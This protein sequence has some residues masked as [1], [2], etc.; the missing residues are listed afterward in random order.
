MEGSV[1][2][3]KLSTW[4]HENSGLFDF[5]SKDLF[6]KKFHVRLS[7][8]VVMEAVRK[9]YDVQLRE[10]TEDFVSARSGRVLLEI[11]R[12]SQGKVIVQVPEQARLWRTASNAQKLK[13][14]DFL[15]F[16]RLKMRVKEVHCQG[17]SASKLSERDDYETEVSAY[18][19]D[20]D[21]LDVSPKSA[22]LCRICYETGEIDNP[23]ISPCACK[24]SMS[25]I[26]VACLRKW[27]TG[28]VIQKDLNGTLSYFVRDIACE[29]CKVSLP[30]RVEFPVGSGVVYELSGVPKPTFPHIVLESKVRGQ[31]TKGLHVV[32]LQQHD[33][34]RE[35]KFGRAVDAD[36]RITDISVSRHHSVISLKNGGFYLQDKSSRFGTLISDGS[37]ALLNPGCTLTVQSGRTLITLSLKK[38]PIFGPV[39]N[40]FCFRKKQTDDEPFNTPVLLSSRQPSIN[41]II[42]RAATDPSPD[43]SRRPSRIFVV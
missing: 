26:H 19:S 38:R 6:S 10:K 33:G 3:V 2:V 15:K 41:R 5:E 21:V 20:L 43:Y 16:G 37:Q 35:L 17:A 24:G 11:A 14:G 27:M 4:N 32:G 23:L 28:K 34:K 22:N 8:Q 40:A 30:S 36:L 1:L 31:R 9:D 18:C 39:L 7:G 12:S 25:S 42:S 29:L 13:A